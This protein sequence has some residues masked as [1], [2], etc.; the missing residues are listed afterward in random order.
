MFSAKKTLAEAWKITQL[1]KRHLFWYGFLP[2]FFA[3]GVGAVIIMIQAILLKNSSLFLENKEEVISVVGLLKPV[4]NWILSPEVPT[5]TAIIT[6]V[7]VF[8]LAYMLPVFCE[9]A[10][11][12]MTKNRGEDDEMGSG[13]GKGMSCFLP[14]FEFS[15]MQ[16]T[17]KP[18]SMF[19]EF[20]FIARI[21]GKQAIP[22]LKPLF[23]IIVILGSIALFFFTFAAQF[24]ALKKQNMGDSVLS[25]LKFVS[26]FFSETMKVLVLFIFIELRTL[27]NVLVIFLIPFVLFSM[28]G[29]IA[30]GLFGI[31]AQIFVGFVI[32]SLAAS[33][34]GVLFV[35]KNVAWT[36]VFLRLQE[37]QAREDADD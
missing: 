9:G 1:N 8:L 23:F 30:E 6:I 24:I 19:L 17:I 12:L 36:L 20:L 3:M 18:Y 37:I 29:I 21:L 4:W 28:G 33:I 15:L 22:F 16:N 11:I 35:Y 27:F 32:L 31:I 2:S 7:T 34:S 25:S 26:R 5:E 13:F 14:M 10:I